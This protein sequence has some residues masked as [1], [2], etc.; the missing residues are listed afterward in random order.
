MFCIA[1]KLFS[2]VNAANKQ[3]YFDGQVLT[4]SSL[5]YKLNTIG[6]H[7]Q[8]ATIECASQSRNYN[9]IKYSKP[10]CSSEN[11]IR[12]VAKPLKMLTAERQA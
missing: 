3:K 7:P 5:I 6:K 4:I 2:V 8:Q 9:G 12:E 10:T 11:G 1:K